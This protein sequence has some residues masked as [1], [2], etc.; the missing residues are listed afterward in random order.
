[1][2]NSRRILAAFLAGQ[3]VQVVLQIIANAMGIVKTIIW[4][5][6]A[7]FLLALAVFMGMCVAGS[8]IKEN[9]T[10]RKR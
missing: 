9:Q 7:G 3:V 6:A 4:T 5:S 10:V 8:E 2:I 1:M